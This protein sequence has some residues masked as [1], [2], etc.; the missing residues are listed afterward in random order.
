MASIKKEITLLILRYL[1]DENLHETAHSLERQTGCFFNLRYFESLV[2][3]GRFDEVEKYL[4]GACE[5]AGS[6]ATLLKYYKHSSNVPSSPVISFFVREYEK[7]S[8]Q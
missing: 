2:L 7:V 6:A 1:K 5:Q 3:A 8:P 4:Y